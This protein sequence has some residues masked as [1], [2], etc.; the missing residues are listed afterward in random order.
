[1]THVSTRPAQPPGPAVAGRAMSVFAAAPHSTD[2]PAGHYVRAVEDVAR[3]SERHGCQGLLIGAGHRLVDGWAVA[4]AVVAATDRLSPLVMVQP[5]YLHPY[6]VAR[7]VVAFGHLYHRRVGLY[8]AADGLRREARALGDHTPRDRRYDHLVEFG[9][10]IKRLLNGDRVSIEGAFYTLRGLE[11]SPP[12]EPTLMPDML[13]SGDDDGAVEA[14][15]QLDATCIGYPEG[16]GIEPVVRLDARVTAGVRVGII[17]REDADLAWSIALRRFPPDRRTSHDGPY[18]LVPFEHYRTSCPY[19]V[20]SYDQIVVELLRYLRA[21]VR[22]YL[23]DVPADEE[24]LY[25]TRV[26]FERAAGALQP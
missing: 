14:A 3:W 4:G 6:A 7:M 16:P 20:G 13:L 26:V 9:R 22:T 15:L 17:A 23:L 11:L 10:I 8:L 1:M 19:L 21:E 12:L 25:H 18:W 2:L 24:D 5:T